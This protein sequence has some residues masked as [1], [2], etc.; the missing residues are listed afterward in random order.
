[1]PTTA[2][3]CKEAILSL[4]DRTGSSRHAIK[5]YIL[6]KHGKVPCARTMAAVL[7]GDCF[8]KINHGGRFKLAPV[9]IR[10]GKWVRLSPQQWKTVEAAAAAASAP[11][12]TAAT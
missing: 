6:A 3:M 5:A 10:P 9:G 7:D 8:V 12:A 4:K 1:M 11:V 2:D